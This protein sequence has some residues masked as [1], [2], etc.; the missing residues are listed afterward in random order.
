VEPGEVSVPRK[1]RRVPRARS[2]PATTL[3]PGSMNAT[4]RTGPLKPG[5]EGHFTRTRVP[6]LRVGLIFGVAGAQALVNDT[7]AVATART[8]GDTDTAVPSGAPSIAKLPPGQGSGFGRRLASVPSGSVAI[9]AS[10]PRAVTAVVCRRPFTGVAPARPYGTRRPEV[11]ASGASG[12]VI[13][14]GPRLFD[15]R[16]GCLY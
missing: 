3:Q 10:T 5:H 9:R 8:S 16:A 15:T 1:V 7:P 13:P 2:F 4:M 11:N 6:L 14:A 12:G